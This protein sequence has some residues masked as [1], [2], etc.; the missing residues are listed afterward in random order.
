MNLITI[1]NISTGDEITIG[2]EV[3]SA[4]E[5]IGKGQITSVTNMT[6]GETYKIQE[7]SDDEI[8]KEIESVLVGMQ[9]GTLTA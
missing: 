6:I 9:A 4:Y 1:K 5:K 3:W 7:V 8:R 2:D